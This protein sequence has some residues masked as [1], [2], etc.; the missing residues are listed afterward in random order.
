MALHE[1]T[2]EFVA[3]GTTVGC[4][5]RISWVAGRFSPRGLGHPHSVQ[6]FDSNAKSP[7]QAMHR[8]SVPR[9]IN[10]RCMSHGLG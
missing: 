5:T 8:S 9:A 7:E 1:Q 3:H 6:W 10:T 4:K 2:A